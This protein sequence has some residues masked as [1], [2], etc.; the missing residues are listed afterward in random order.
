[1]LAIVSSNASAKCSADKIVF[2]RAW[3]DLSNAERADYLAAAQ[4]MY[5]LPA[6]TPRSIAPGVRNRVDDYLYLHINQSNFIHF[7]ALLLP[8][9]RQFLWAWEQDLREQC[10]YKGGLPYWAWERHANQL[11]SP[12][13]TPES[14]GTNGEYVADRPDSILKPVGLPGNPDLTNMSYHRP[15]GT[16]G[17]C[18]TDGPFVNAT[19][20]LG[21]TDESREDDVFGI[22]GHPRCLRRDFADTMPMSLTWSLISNL[23]V[24][25]DFVDFHPLL[26]STAHP[27]SHWYVGGDASDLYASPNEPVFFLLH[28]Q[29]DRV[30]AIWQGLDYATRRDVVDGTLTLGNI[31]PSPEGTL[32]SPMQMGIPAGGEMT[33]GDAK[34]TVEGE[35]C[36]VYL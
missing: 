28:G 16:G 35:Y 14:F 26:E 20:N 4:C 13:F 5:T 22:G 19:L 8:W 34:S 33:I 17:G 24:L 3:D 36:Y 27:M 7:S 32:D 15:P 9:H 30:W 18:V 10:G 25:D 2:R 1:M 21:P 31:P 12:V 11:D 6:R 29:I 23:L